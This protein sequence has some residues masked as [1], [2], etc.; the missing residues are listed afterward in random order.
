MTSHREISADLRD[1]ISIRLSDRELGIVGMYAENSVKGVLLS[2]SAELPFAIS[3][4]DDHQDL[5]IECP[6]GLPAKYITGIEPVGEI[7]F[8]FFERLQE[9]SAWRSFRA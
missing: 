7:E 4:G 5:R 1:I 3:P 6:G 9:S 8:Q 2:I